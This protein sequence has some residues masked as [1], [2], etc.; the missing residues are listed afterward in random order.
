MLL[1]PKPERLRPRYSEGAK[2]DRV[3]ESR[4]GGTPEPLRRQLFALLGSEKVLHKISDLVLCGGPG[5]ARRR[6]FGCG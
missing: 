2:P 4:S 3:E 1:D 5:G 6:G